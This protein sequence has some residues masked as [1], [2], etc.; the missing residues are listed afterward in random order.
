MRSLLEAEE[1]IKTNSETTKNFVKKRFDY[2]LDYIDY[3]WPKQKFVV[4]LEQA[5]LILFEDQARWKIEN[6]LTDV[7]GVPNYLDY[8]YLDVLEAMKPDAV[9]II[10]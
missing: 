4:T 7:R 10:K 2:E 5:M 6:N 3:S 8:I 1:Y 9:T